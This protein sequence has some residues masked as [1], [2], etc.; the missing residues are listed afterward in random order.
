MG[1]TTTATARPTRASEVGAACEAVAGD[2]CSAGLWLCQA[3][4]ARACIRDFALEDHPDPTCRGPIA[5]VGSGCAGGGLGP[6]AVVLAA[7]ALVWRRR[8]AAATGA[9]ALA[10]ASQ[11]AAG[12]TRE[13]RAAE[14]DG[15]SLE[16]LEPLPDAGTTILGTAQS[17]VLP[18][19]AWTAGL[20][21]QLTLAPLRFEPVDGSDGD[22]LVDAQ[23]W[24]DA[25]FGVGMLGWL[26]LALDVLLVV[27]DAGVGLVAL[28]RSDDD[29]AGVHLGDVRLVPRANL[30]DGRGGGLGLALL[31][32]LVLPT[33]DALAFTSQGFAVEPRVAVDVTLGPGVVLAADLGFRWSAERLVYD[34][35]QGSAL[36]WSVGA[37]V[38]LGH[39]LDVLGT[40][41]GRVDFAAARDPS[42][43]GQSAGAGAGQ[44]PIE[45]ALGARWLAPFGLDLTLGVGKG[46][47]RGLG[48]SD[49]RVLLTVAFRTSGPDSDGDGLLNEVDPC[50]LDAE[51]VDG[52]QDD[53]GCPDRDDDADGVVD[54]RDRCPRVAED[55]DGFEDDDGCPDED[56][57]KD[58]IADQA[59]RCPRVAGVREKG[60][61]PWEKVKVTRERLEITDKVF[62]DLDRATIDAE[63]F[64]LLD[65]IAE[66]LVATPRLKSVEV[67][68]HTDSAG[69]EAHNQALSEGRAKAVVDYLVK[70][71][72]ARERLVPK[73]YGFT[74]PL[75]APAPGGETEE[76]AAK[77]R[78]VEFVILEQVLEEEILH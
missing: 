22:A 77:N 59:D 2:R 67:A 11:I 13:A 17:R 39:G 62:F 45:A 19:L 52:F 76:Q 48:A 50:P 25:G 61:C 41:L 72:V 9:L 47:L 24:L 46:L 71:G 23:V 38:P 63:S 57:D 18:H 8:R 27:G 16:L 12:A 54:A 36:T 35:G 58:G 4:G 32:P 73:G 69:T 6:G 34:V 21:I 37:R 33:G 15:T 20:T 10:V 42:D 68:G 64:P 29:V 55:K 66:V 44:R 51:D 74:R 56:D 60:G 65:E 31:L 40:L 30:V 14:P 1:W 26:D 43:L 28:G 78:R 5:V 3:D 49:L 75:V 7:L 53:D 70:K